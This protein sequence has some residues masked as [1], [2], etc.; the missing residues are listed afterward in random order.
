MVTVK[1]STD[2]ADGVQRH[3]WLIWVAG[4]VVAIV[5]VLAIVVAIKSPFTEGKVAQSLE[6]TVRA[7]VSFGKYRMTYFPHPGCLAENV[8]FTREGSPANIPP[9]V[10]IQR[11]EIESH[12]ADMI[13]RPGYVALV[14]VNGLRVQIPP[15]GANAGSPTSPPSESSNVRVGEIVADGAVLEIGRSDEHTAA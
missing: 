4:A 8:R 15:R 12:Y 1:A 14:K 10:T 5:C 2:K 13:V 9:I 11:L 6:E 7:K 3:R